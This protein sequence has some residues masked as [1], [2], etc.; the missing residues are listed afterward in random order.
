MA[1]LNYLISQFFNAL[2]PIGIFVIMPI[3]TVKMITRERIKRDNMRKDIIL[4]AMEKN[5]DIDIE[6]MM[7]KLNG[8]KKLIKEKQLTKLL[9]GSI[10]VI[11][12]ILVYV[13]MAIL[14]KIEGFDNATFIGLS[15]VAVPPLAIGI[16]LLL[17]Y[18]IGKKMLANEIEAEERAKVSGKA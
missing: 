3:I 15:I 1:P 2:I 11:F 18:F 8:P 14:M 5:T 6:E 12:S 7:K 9:I 10:L 4:A 17:N 16:A 13:A